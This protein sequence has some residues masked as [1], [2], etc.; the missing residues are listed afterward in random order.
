MSAQAQNSKSVHFFSLM[1]GK[2]RLSVKP[3]SVTDAKALCL[4]SHYLKCVL[5]SL[6]L[7]CLNFKNPK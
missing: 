2:D 1:T 7:G 4:T 6:N 3:I 5:Y